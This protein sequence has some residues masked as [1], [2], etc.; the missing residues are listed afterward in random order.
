MFK[1]GLGDVE[2]QFQSVQ[3]LRNLGLDII[4]EMPIVKNAI[5]MRAM[6]L[7]GNLPKFAKNYG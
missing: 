5:M 1:T 3:W 6:G 2:N 4:D 7:K